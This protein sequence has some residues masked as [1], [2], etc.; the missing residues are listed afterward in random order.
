MKKSFLILF[1][2]TQTLLCQVNTEKYRNFGDSTGISGIFKF[3]ASAQ[4]GNTDLQELGSEIHLYYRKPVSTFLLILKGE[5]GWN[6]GQQFSNGAL[7]H[8]RYVHELNLNLKWEAFTQVNY[9]RSLL[10][11]FRVLGGT[12]LRFKLFE[13]NKS[14]LW[15]GSAYMLEYERY[16]K[17][18]RVIN[19]KEITANRW[20]NYLS[21]NLL[22]KTNVSLSS[23]IYYQPRFDL[24]KD[25]RILTE[26]SLLISLSGHFTLSV[27]FD[28][29]YDRFPAADLKNVDTNSKI[30]FVYVW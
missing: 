3:D 30:G 1:V 24:L 17:S 21:Y 2:L 19:K 8:V 5:Y 25:A 28:L 23:V 22:I 26:N 6:N 29:R 7:G 16:E 4:T 13:A 9:D 12:G 11:L 10:L 20:S 15:F 27:E 18:R 14:V